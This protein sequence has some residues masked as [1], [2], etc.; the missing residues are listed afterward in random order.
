MYTYRPRN[1][2]TSRNVERRQRLRLEY[3]LPLQD[4]VEDASPYTHTAEGLFHTW[5]GRVWHEDLSGVGLG[6]GWLHIRWGVC[7]PD[8]GVG[9]H[10]PLQMI[11]P[12]DEDFLSFFTWPT[13][14][15]DGALSWIALP[16]EDKRWDRQRVDP[17]GFIQAATGWKPSPLQPLVHVRQ[18]DNLRA[19]VPSRL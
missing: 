3:D 17:G 7:S 9:E 18:L 16:V 8:G 2:V 6:P 12:P 10:A 5:A 14:T 11:D 19:V 13:S 4:A 1:P 15:S